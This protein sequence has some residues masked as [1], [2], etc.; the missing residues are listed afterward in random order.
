MW[1]FAL[2][3]WS[4]SRWSPE[5]PAGTSALP[6]VLPAQ[7]LI[8]KALG[9]FASTTFSIYQYALHTAQNFSV[10]IVLCSSP[11]P[12]VHFVVV[13]V[14]SAGAS[15]TGLTLA[16]PVY[17]RASVTGRGCLQPPKRPRKAACVFPEAEAWQERTL[18][19]CD[20]WF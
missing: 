12:A 8:S 3:P 14:G 9:I 2:W 10:W 18:A 7:L 15:S 16:G 6:L 20:Y 13:R 4:C 11:L 5:T 1:R 17:A 19:F